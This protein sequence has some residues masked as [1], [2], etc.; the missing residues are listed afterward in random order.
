MQLDGLAAPSRIAI[1][2]AE[3]EIGSLIDALLAPQVVPGQVLDDGPQ[4]G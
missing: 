2:S 3:N 1:S 4:E